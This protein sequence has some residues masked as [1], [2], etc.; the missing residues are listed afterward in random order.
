MFVSSLDLKEFRG[1]KKF[2]EPL[3]L[4][5]FNVL[6]GRNNSG[7]SAILH[8]LS[9]LPYPSFGLPMG[10]SVGNWNKRERV[11]DYLLGGW[12]S[13][14]YRY[15]GAASLKFKV[16]AKIRKG[17]SVVVYT[18]DLP[19]PPVEYEIVEKA[20][21][22]DISKGGIS[23][24]VDDK[25]ADARACCVSLAI[26]EERA[27]DLVAFVPNDS[28][29]FNA[30]KNLLWNNWS[31]IEKREA[32]YSIVREI[33]NKSVNDTFTEVNPRRDGLY[34]RKEVNGKPFYVKVRDLGD[35]VKKILS[36]LL[37]LDASSP[38]L[39]LWDDFEASVHPTLIK[40]AL[41]WL[42]KT[43][44]TINGWTHQ[45]SSQPQPKTPF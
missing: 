19:P 23:F 30:L 7:K 9:L 37:W 45:Q 17:K 28:T 38:E 10:L 36:V 4:A 2:K 20:C 3:K 21:H 41:E 25:I 29:F 27:K 8:A 1:I 33:I 13:A 34:V 43:I 35:G 44:T 14:I 16:K 6:V 11:F 42:V 26:D 32:H 24:S 18:A 31:A 39:V 40:L 22:V 12:E 5:K 15:A